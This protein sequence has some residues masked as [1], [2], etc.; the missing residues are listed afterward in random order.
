MNDAS[1]FVGLDVHKVSIAVSVLFPGRSEPIRWEVP[2][3]ASA[4]RRLARRLKRDGGDSVVCCYEAGVCGFAIQ[5]RLEAEG[6]TC[7]VIAPSLIP[8]KPGE[9]IKTDRR[10]ADKLAHL[11]RAGLL[12]EVQ[13]PTT[14]EEAVRDLVRARETAQQD[15][16]RCRHR[17]TKLLLRKGIVYTAGRAWTE[18]HRR[19]LSHVS[20]EHDAERLVFEDA[21]LAIAQLEDRVQH[22]DAA[23]EAVAQQPPYR[24]AVGWLC[25]LRGVK[26]LTA[27][28]LLSE[29]HG[30][31]R[32]TSAR[33]LMGYLGLV[34]SVD[35]SADR[36]HRGRIT[37]A[38]NAHVRRILVETAW[39]YPSSP[40]HSHALRRR[41]H[42]QPAWVI[43]LADKAQQRLHRRYWALVRHGKP[44]GKAVVAIARE[45][46]GFVWALLY[47]EVASR[48]A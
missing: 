40:G 17:L 44:P 15:L 3:E 23:L 13:P 30:F 29:L 28:T 41:R 6:V 33:Q 11:L 45:L 20:L 9:H 21:R 37:R 16:T 25:C 2:N 27:M 34:T 26:T 22:L 5:R 18:G 32:F 43:A 36:V 24:E 31:R 35:A 19:W 48:V 1:T 4:L 8:V 10:D 42:G 14:A 47:R 38:G 46:V 7:Q 39:H 12:T